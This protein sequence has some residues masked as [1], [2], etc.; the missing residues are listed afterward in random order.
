MD[1]NAAP[2]EPEPRGAPPPLSRVPTG[3]PG[4]DAVL[5]GG[6]LAGDAYLVVG[7]PGTGKTTLGNQLA[8]AHAAAG[9]DPPAPPPVERSTEVQPIRAERAWRPRTK[10]P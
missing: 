1:P 3:V 7:Q 8:F 2:T 5:G 10:R 4:L 6:F 9:P